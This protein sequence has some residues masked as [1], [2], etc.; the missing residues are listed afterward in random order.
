MARYATRTCVNCGIRKPQPDMYQKE[1]Y[2]ETGKSK[3]GVS[4]ATF[5]GVLLG[6]QKSANSFNRWLFNTNQRTYK[7][8]KTVWVCG[9]CKGKVK[10]GEEKSGLSILGEWLIVGFIIFLVLV[11]IS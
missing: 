10:S 4:K 8:K 2:V 5:A 11:G 6:D 1:T 7:R 9:S 3:A